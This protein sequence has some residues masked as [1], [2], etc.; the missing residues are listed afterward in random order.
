MSFGSSEHARLRRV[1]RKLDLLI[2]HFGLE[3]PSPFSP[4]VQAAIDEGNTILAI[5]RYREETGAGL[6]EAKDFIDSYRQ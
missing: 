6:R 2:E 4:Q 5:K 3:S 1:E